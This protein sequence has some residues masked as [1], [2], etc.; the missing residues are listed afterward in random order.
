M[1]IQQP[2][3]MQDAEEARKRDEVGS[4]C[5]QRAFGLFFTWTLLNLATLVN[6]ARI[7]RKKEKEIGELFA[8]GGD[9]RIY[10]ALCWRAP[11]ARSSRS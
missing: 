1:K 2:R 8:H 10:G 6:L 5:L 7:F 3:Y 9:V 4:A 11:G